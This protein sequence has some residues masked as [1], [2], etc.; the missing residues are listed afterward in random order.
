MRRQI[1]KVFIVGFIVFSGTQSIAQSL[2]INVRE[3]MEPTQNMKIETLIARF[4]ALQKPSVD[5]GKMSE[6]LAKCIAA[7]SVH[8]LKLDAARFLEITEHEK[9]GIPLSQLEKN[10]LEVLTQKNAYMLNI[11]AQSCDYYDNNIALRDIKS[12]TVTVT[13][14]PIKQQTEETKIPTFTLI[15][16]KP[17]PSQSDPDSKNKEK[18]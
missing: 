1:A 14:T 4:Y 2:I 15:T 6:Y 9:K 8:I 11:A 16:P 5:Q 7:S 10:E 18:L 17:K 13:T 3:L 12:D